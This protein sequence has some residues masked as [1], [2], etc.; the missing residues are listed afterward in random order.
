MSGV[1]S[2]HRYNRA[3]RSHTSMYEALMRAQ[4]DEF[5]SWLELN[6]DILNL[7]DIDIMSLK[8]LL[9]KMRNDLQPTDFVNLMSGSHLT[10]L[11]TA[12]A[13]FQISDR[14]PMAKFWQSYL[15]LVGLLLNVIRATREGNWEVHMSCPRKMLPW[16]FAMDH[17][18]YSRY[19]PLYWWDMHQLHIT[20]PEVNT[21]MQLGEFAVQRTSHKPFSQLSVDQTIEHTVN[22]DSKT[23]I[24]KCSAIHWNINCQ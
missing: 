21:Q 7:T 6:P 11:S 16:I 20:H 13:V 5:G 2:G 4:W 19:V 14:G 12:L 18:N 15:D 10:K 23:R 17:T 3:V 22:R 24:D 9:V 1:L 8:T